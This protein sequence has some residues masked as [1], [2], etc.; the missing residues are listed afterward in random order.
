MQ[1]RQIKAKAVIEQEAHAAPPQEVESAGL[2]GRPANWPN[3]TALLRSAAGQVSSIERQERRGIMTVDTPHE[4]SEQL[5]VPLVAVPEL[6]ERILE[7]Y[8]RLWQ[9]ETWLRRLVYVELR[10]AEGDSWAERFASVEKAKEADKRLTHMPTPEDDPLS[11]AQLSDLK[12][13]ISAEWKLFAPFLP[14]QSIWDG[15]L[16]EV[17]QVRNRVAHFR[18]GHHDDL[19]RVVQLLR[20]LDQ[21]FWRFCTSYNNPIPVLPQSDDPVVAHFLE[22]DLFPWSPVGENQWARVGVADPNAPLFV[23]IEV[24]CRPWAKWSTPI[25]GTSGLLY[26]VRIHARHQ[27]HFEYRRFLESTAAIHPHL[28][29]ICLDSMAQDFRSTI[30]AVLGSDLVIALIERLTKAANYCLRSNHWH[31]PERAVQEMADASPEYILGPENP[32]AFLDPEMPCSIFCV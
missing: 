20:D 8:A 22:L 1:R 11:F 19:Q 14:P 28:V 7:T 10:A 21:G 2:K 32:L 13:V 17:S 15:K 12:K 29:H 23:T 27:R 26:D 31:G 4:D 25:A 9:F 6:P 3:R 24:L 5:K 18:L 30:P 16:E